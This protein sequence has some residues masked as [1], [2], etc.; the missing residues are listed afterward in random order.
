MSGVN[1]TILEGGK[2]ENFGQVTKLRTSNGTD[3]DLWVPK[4]DVETKHLS[5]KKN[6][7]HYTNQYEPTAAEKKEGKFHDVYGWDTITVSVKKKVKGKKKKIDP[8]TGLETDVPVVV[9]VD[10]DENLVETELPTSIKIT[11]KPKNLNYVDGQDITIDGIIVHGYLED[12]TD[13]G[14]VPFDELSFEPAIA[15]ATGDE[16]SDGD[17]VN[18]I[19]IQYTAHRYTYSSPYTPITESVSY[20]SPLI[21]GTND[22]VPCTLGGSGVAD[23]YLTKYDGDLYAMRISGD[24]HMNLVNVYSSPYSSGGEY[25]AIGEN[26]VYLAR[27]VSPTRTSTDRFEIMV[28]GGQITE[29]PVSTKNPT[30]AGELQPAGGTTEVTVSWLPDDLEE[31]LTDTYEIT[32]GQGPIP[33]SS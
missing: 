7:L 27:G 23:L 15:S 24:D 5:V 6:G 21:L 9:D 19:R 33:P 26:N 28:W 22:G 17:G 1:I 31:E 12:G 11:K 10:D 4:T 29:V 2:A 8:S 16:Y 13:W 25:V 32:V 20:A 30:Q 14:E 3:H 18:A